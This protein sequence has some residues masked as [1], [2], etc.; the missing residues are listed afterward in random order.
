MMIV[1]CFRE[2]VLLRQHGGRVLPLRLLQVQ[3]RLRP[4]QQG[5]Q[6]V[7]GSPLGGAGDILRVTAD[8]A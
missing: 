8:Q 4:G 2:E 3:A 6:G 5:P 7:Q 1:I